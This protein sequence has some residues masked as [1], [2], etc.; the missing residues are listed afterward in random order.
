M[1]F[2]TSV[3]F[4]ND[5]SEWEY[6]KR[7]NT[8]SGKDLSDGGKISITNWS[9]QQ[10]IPRSIEKGY[11]SSGGVFFDQETV[12][13]FNGSP[14]AAIEMKIGPRTTKS[15]NKLNPQHI[16]IYSVP[17]KNLVRETVVSEYDASGE[18]ELSTET[19]EYEYDI[20]LADELFV[21]QPPADA[22]QVPSK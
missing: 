16:L 2:L 19:T 22:T 20:P 10:F 11:A 14:C 13:S 8:Y 6:N 3:V 15:G 9:A 21:F 12:S 4:R 18:R 7:Q 5:I 1:D 17:G